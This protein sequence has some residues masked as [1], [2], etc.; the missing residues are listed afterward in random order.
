[1]DVVFG[2]DFGSKLTGNTVIA[3]LQDEEILFL[4]TEPKVDADEF[5]L[6]AAKHFKP[7]LIFIDAPLSLPGVYR[8]IPDCDNYHF[9]K[10]DLACRAMSPMFLGGLAARAIELK[11][12]LENLGAEVKETYPRIMANRFDLKDIG[13]KS[14][15]GALKECALVLRDLFKSPYKFNLGDLK[16]WHHL[17]ALLALMS[18][19][20]YLSDQHEVF[21]DP[22]EGQI[23]V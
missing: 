15:K 11:A 5:I 3:I 20:A 19:M 4:D 22:R 12:K 17:D 1:M 8:Q 7:S 18:A 9:R 6:N 2:I 10:A 13:Y 14:S 23:M 16:T 21:G